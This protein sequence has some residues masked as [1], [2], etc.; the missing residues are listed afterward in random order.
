VPFVDG[1]QVYR[2]QDKPQ[3]FA[4]NG[5]AV[6]VAR[7]EVLQRGSLYGGDVRALVMSAEESIDIDSPLDLD[8]LDCLLAKRR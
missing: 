7:T 5:P 8:L 2:R 1:P 3:V 4:R 6:L